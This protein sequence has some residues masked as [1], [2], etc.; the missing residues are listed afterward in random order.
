[1]K[2]VKNSQPILLQTK[3]KTGLI[4]TIVVISLIVIALLITI[5]ILLIPKGSGDD[6]S[7]EIT[8]KDTAAKYDDKY[9]K[10]RKADLARFVSN[11][12]DYQTNNN[13]KTPWYNGATDSKFVALYVDQNC[14]AR[15]PDEA[16]SSCGSEFRDPE[17]GVPYH[18]VF[19]KVLAD[20]E[21]ATFEADHGIRVYTNAKCGKN[22]GSLTTSTTVRNFAL[23]YR[24]GDGTYACADNN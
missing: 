5:I 15:T 23:L 24:L 14:R 11:A 13:G 4:I 2:E 12:T 1:M 20:P 7:E 22:N 6:S 16:D 10:K 3:K 21:T 9:D 8:Q 18:F 19:E 17:D